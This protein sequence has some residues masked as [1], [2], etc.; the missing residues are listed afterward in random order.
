M[1]LQLAFGRQCRE[2]RLGLDVSQQELAA[3]VGVTRGYIA[4][5]ERGSANP[6]LAVV[7]RVALALGLEFELVARAS[8]IDRGARQRDLVHARCSGYVGRRLGR[9]G[10]HVEREVEVVR[11]RYHGWVDI[12]A[13]HP[14]SA[15]MLVIEVKT[16]LDDVGAV[17]RQ[18]GWYE[19]SAIDVARRLG[20]RPRRVAGWVLLLASDEVD[21]AVRSNREAL[22]MAFTGRARAMLDVLNRPGSIPL[23]RGLGL[24]DPRTKRRDWV[25]RTGVDGRR[26]PLPYLDYADAARRLA[27]R[28]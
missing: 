10:W 13:F 25:Q 3:S 5:V 16:R 20:W 21:G 28:G 9:A 26:S 14:S 2:T 1:Q 11:G 7:E 27:R 18:L 15:T 24:I 4:N 23:G 19:Q 8:T 17:E 6:S 12:V 22:A